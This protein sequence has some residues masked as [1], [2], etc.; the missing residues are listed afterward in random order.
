MF[1]DHFVGFVVWSI[2]KWLLEGSLTVDKWWFT[3][4]FDYAVISVFHQKNR[5][6]LVFE[7]LSIYKKLRNR[8][9]TV[10]LSVC[11]VFTLYRW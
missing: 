9:P 6:T 4:L 2:F 3:G 8:D 11:F 10:F 1:F 7:K 5:K